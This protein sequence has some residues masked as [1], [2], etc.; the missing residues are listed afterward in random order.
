MANYNL[1]HGALLSDK[2]E[3]S[4]W[5]SNIMETVSI[6]QLAAHRVGRPEL[7][8]LVSCMRCVTTMALQE[9]LEDFVGE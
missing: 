6:Q 5:D 9:A 8:F 1:I 3:F 2:G 7:M 4:T